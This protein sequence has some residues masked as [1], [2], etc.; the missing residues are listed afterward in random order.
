MQSNAARDT[1]ATSLLRP[2]DSR[3]MLRRGGP[4]KRSNTQQTPRDAPAAPREPKH[5]TVSN[6]GQNGKIFL[7]CVDLGF[8][9][10]LQALTAS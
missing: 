7:R 8:F 9:A 2:K 4:L 10:A 6:V 3:E 5:F 1:S